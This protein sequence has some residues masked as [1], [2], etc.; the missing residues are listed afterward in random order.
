[1]AEPFFFPNECRSIGSLPQ[2]VAEKVR[3]AILGTPLGV[4]SISTSSSSL[5]SLSRV[6]ASV[7]LDDLQSACSIASVGSDSASRTIWVI[8]WDRLCNPAAALNECGDSTLLQGDK[9]AVDYLLRKEFNF[10]NPLFVCQQVM[11]MSHLMMCA[12]VFDKTRSSDSEK[13]EHLLHMDK[14][15]QEDEVGK[16]WFISHNSLVSI[17]AHDKHPLTL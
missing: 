10:D 7:S 16:V 11:M 3:D 13:T 15:A 4:Q 2:R 6:S 17:S 8:A 12:Y 5:G 14:R 9:V 1:V